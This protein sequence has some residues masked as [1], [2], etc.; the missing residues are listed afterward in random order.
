MAFAAWLDCL[1]ADGTLKDLALGWDHVEGT[2]GRS[3]NSQFAEPLR[4]L[5]Q[6]ALR[7]LWVLLQDESGDRRDRMMKD[8]TRLPP[9]VCSASGPSLWR[10]ATPTAPP[11]WR[12]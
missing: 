8:L 3:D 12:S 9:S 5:G 2:L 4:A 7:R 10:S 1:R 6:E 11:D